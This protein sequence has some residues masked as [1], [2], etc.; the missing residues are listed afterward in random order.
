MNS[1]DFPSIADE[2]SMSSSIIETTVL[3]QEHNINEQHNVT[4]KYY[5]QT[6]ANSPEDIFLILSLTHHL[7]FCRH[8]Y[9]D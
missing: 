5:D 8:S 2:P 7:G 4:G 1:E 3:N 6:L 9:K